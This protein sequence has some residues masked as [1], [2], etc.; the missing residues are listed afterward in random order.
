[1]LKV[2]L[3]SDLRIGVPHFHEAFFGEIEGLETAATAVF[4]KCQKGIDPLYSEELGWRD[5]PQGAKEK[6]VL[7]WFAELIEFFLDAVK[8]VASVPNIQQRPLAQPDQPLQGSTADCKLDIGFMSDPRANQ[9]S[10]CH[11][12]QVLVPRELKSNL[13]DDRHS[14]TWLDLARYAREVLTT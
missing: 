3:G 5:W 6:D 9:D 7:K 11:W 12:S 10:R 14:K 1:V 8:E 13:D 4:M 2:E